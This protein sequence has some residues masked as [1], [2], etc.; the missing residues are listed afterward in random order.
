MLLIY[1]AAGGAFG[2]LCRYLMMGWIG[3][4]AGKDF[5]FATLAVNVLGS[6]LLGVLIGMIATYLPRSRELHALLAI[7]AL[8]GFTTFSTFA[9]DAYMLMERGEILSA[10]AYTVSSVLMGVSAF[11]IGMWM[12]RYIA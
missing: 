3:R 12:F 9:M 10:I 1:V 5:P 4:F 2:S 11:F 8:G 7:G 6:F